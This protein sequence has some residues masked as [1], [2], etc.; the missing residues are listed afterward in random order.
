MKIL[1]L[2]G[3]PRKAGT[4]AALAEEFRRGALAAGHQVE[5]LRAAEMK[6]HPCLGCGACKQGEIPCVYAGQDEMDKL[7]GAVLEVDGLVL[8]SP[9]YYF[10][11]STQLKTVLDRFYG[12]NKLLR[13]QE[14]AA[15]LISA[16]A[17]AEPQAMEALKSQFRL[18][19]GYLGWQNRGEMLALSAAQPE[20]LTCAQKQMAFDLGRQG[21]CPEIE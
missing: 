8:V 2:L 14:K 20:E 21:K 10:G 16:G 18:L 17:D 19:C 13:S 11:L 12:F 6:V 5:M 15:W 3:S 1:M 7:R 9:L 4:T